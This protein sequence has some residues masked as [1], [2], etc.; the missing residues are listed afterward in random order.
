M[1]DSAADRDGVPPLSP[2]PEEDILSEGGLR[3]PPELSFGRKLWWWFD[4]IILVKLARLR[5]IGILFAIGLVIV[6]W[7]TLVAYYEKWTRAAAEQ[8]AASS[9]TEFYCPMHPSVIRDN[10]KDKCPICFM[11][12]SKRKKGESSDEALPAGIVNRVQLSPYRVVLAGIQTWKVDYLPLS[13]EITT[14]GYVEFNERRLTQVAARVKGRLD[15]LFVN[16]TGQ[17]VHAGDELATL[18]SPELLVIVQNVVDS[19]R[20][21]NTDLMRIARD[22]LQLLGISD[23]QIDEIVKTGKANT[24]LKIRSPID[25][26]VIKKYVKEGQYVDEGMPLYEVADL[27]TVWIQAQLYEDDIAF[28][29]DEHS[30]SKT[31]KTDGMPIRATTRAFPAES[32]QGALSFVHPHVDPDTR[33]LTVR[34]ELDNPG[35]KLRPGMSATVKL[36]VPPRQLALFAKK[37][38]EEWSMESAVEMLASTL[39]AT[40]RPVMFTGLRPLLTESGKQALLHRGLVLAVPESAVIDTGSQQIVYREE[41]PGTYEGVKVELGPRMSGPE[42]VTYYPVIRGLESGDVV[43]TAGSFLVDAETRLNPA[44]GSI[45]FG[46]TGLNKDSQSSATVRPS[47][48][49]DEEVKVKAVLAR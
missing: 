42:D 1:A 39:G 6:K 44:A 41:S 35:H 26:H 45:Y 46:G 20:S 37:A 7:D 3:A 40:A 5:F 30:Q 24:P 43:V 19:K 15:K 34:F 2:A 18:Y 21:G 11:P 16:Q 23:D 27:S 47:T 17:M 48:P 32:F 49:D 22:R 38:A 14:V 31:K 28:L 4:I 9:D 10:P 13:K 8:R 29:Q 12:L 25:G 36:N 33:T